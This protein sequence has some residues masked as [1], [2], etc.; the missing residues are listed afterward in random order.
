MITLQ[1]LFKRSDYFG[2]DIILHAAAGQKLQTIQQR[3]AERT[4]AACLADGVIDPHEV[5]TV[6]LPTIT[7]HND[8]DARGF[9]WFG[10]VARKFNAANAKDQEAM[11]EAAGAGPQWCVFHQCEHDAEEFNRCAS[12]PSGFQPIC[13]AAQTEQRANRRQMRRAA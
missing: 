12:R 13:K 8:E 3:E 10:R 2:L 6:L 4:I 1:R 9:G 11:Q 5:Q 7:R